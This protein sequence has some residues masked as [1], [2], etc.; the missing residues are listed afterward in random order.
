MTN[1]CMPGIVKVGRTADDPKKRAMQLRTTGVPGRFRVVGCHWA[2]DAARSE[3]LAHHMLKSKRV[4]MDREFFRTD[5]Q[6]ALSVVR[7]AVNVK[8]N[9]SW[10][11]WTIVLA[12][13]AYILAK[14][15][16]R[17]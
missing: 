5:A 6:H 16:G 9:P 1:D 17:L 7:R 2:H 11:V 3:G 14:A 15:N 10:W 13:L 4:A 12:L 8:K